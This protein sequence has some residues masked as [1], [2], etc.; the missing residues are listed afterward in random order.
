VKSPSIKSTAGPG[1][2]QS[3]CWSVVLAA[4][5]EGVTPSQSYEALSEL[6]RVYWRPVYLFLRGHGHSPA[7][8][9]DLTQGF[10][11]DL[12]ESRSFA[13]ADRAKGRF[14]S[15][16]LAALKHFVADEHDRA[17]SQ[18][19]G[20][21]WRFE[22]LDETALQEAESQIASSHGTPETVFERSWA[23]ALLRQTFSRLAEECRVAGKTELYDSLK[24]Y[25]AIDREGIV[26]Y[27]QLS[28]TLR[29][30][31]STL[32]SDLA[33]LRAR[34]RAILREEVSGTVATPADVDD[35]LRYLCRVMAAT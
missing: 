35:E 21:G 32:R 8:A 12:I 13:R 11:A 34:Y 30:P 28:V 2:F 9:Q 7:D 5:G 14:R 22:A 33:R 10:F 15:F 31:A 4:G 20:G 18:K 25:V 17:L 29:R 27:A 3:T 23:A 16:L 6:C 1:S 24:S 26:P 19:R